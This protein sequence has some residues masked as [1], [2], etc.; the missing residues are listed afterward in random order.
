M[1]ARA[2]GSSDNMTIIVVFFDTFELKEPPQAVS[3]S[4]SYSYAMAK[5]QLWHM[6]FAELAICLQLWI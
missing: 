5:Q 3:E 6:H 1:H 2:E 4:E